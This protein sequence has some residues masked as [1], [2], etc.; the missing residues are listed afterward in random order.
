MPFVA[1][2]GTDFTATEGFILL[3]SLQPSISFTIESP[4]VSAFFRFVPP[5]LCDVSVS[6]KLDDLCPGWS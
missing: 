3:L 4:T 5:L 2:S 6:F 1:A